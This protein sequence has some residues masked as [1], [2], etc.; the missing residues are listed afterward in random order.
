MVTGTTVMMG[1]VAF[2]A[3]LELYMVIDTIQLI[4]RGEEPPR[5]DNIFDKSFV[6]FTLLYTSFAFYVGMFWVGIAFCIMSTGYVFFWLAGKYYD[7]R[8]A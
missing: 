2:I 4:R 3:I 8:H 6:V 5:L 1:M 7:R